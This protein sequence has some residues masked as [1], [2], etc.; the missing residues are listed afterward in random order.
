MTIARPVAAVTGAYGYLGSRI[1]TTLESKGWRVVRLVRSPYPADDSSR[2]YDLAAPV[3]SDVLRSVD[4][5][6]HAAYDFSI[7]S[8]TDIWRVNVEGTRRLLGTARDAEVRRILVLSTMSAYDRTTQLYGQAKLAIEEATVAARGCAIRPGLVYGEHPA[9]M[10]GALL[11]ITHLPIVP[12]VAGNARQYPVHV[13]DLMTAIGALATADTLPAG[14]IGVANPTP[15]SFRDLLV[16]LAE[17]EGR[18]CYF[19][20]VPWQLAYWAL[21]VG[22][23][24]PIAL[25]FRSDSLLGL[26]HSAPFVPGVEELEKL[27][28]KLR[29]FQTDPPGIR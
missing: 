8:R 16:A 9:G 15:V 14:P 5:L 7:T 1:C 20:P 28:V 6:V 11:K 25:P 27:G 12:L 24:L 4:L 23:L 18:R 26:V 21:R 3:D 10:A 2:P 17:Q 13:D 19:V 29:A 22:E